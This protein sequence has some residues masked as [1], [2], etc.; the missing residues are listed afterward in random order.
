[1]AQTIITLHL[2]EYQI[3]TYI[4][5]VVIQKASFTL[6]QG[7]YSMLFVEITYENIIITDTISKKCL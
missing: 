7:C 1:M 3:C 4:Y 5:S 2:Y 6:A